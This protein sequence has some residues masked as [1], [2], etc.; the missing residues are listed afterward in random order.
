MRK[1]LL[2]SFL[3]HITLVSLI[4]LF[5]PSSSNT[6]GYPTVYNVG[7][8]SFPKG[9]GPGGGGK[10]TSEVSAEMKKAEE[11]I[12][13]KQLVKEEKGKKKKAVQEQKLKEEKQK[14]LSGKVGEGKEGSGIGSGLKLGEGVGG[15]EVEGGYFGGG[16]Y[17][18]DI[19]RAR[20]SEYWKNPIRGATAIIRATIFYKIMKDGKIK[21]AKIEKSSGFELF[22]QAALRAVLST[23]PLPPLPGEYTGES[24][25]VHLEFEYSP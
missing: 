8:V 10:G 14:A 11:G 1:D 19:M 3:V 21:D 23:N 16:D 24:L 15:A 6:K 4:L 12:G 9:G 7:L 17:Y 2:L 5:S 13:L 20:I 18:I 22:D 25:L